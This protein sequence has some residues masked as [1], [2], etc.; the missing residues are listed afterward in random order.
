MKQKEG[1]FDYFP[2]AISGNPKKIIVSIII[3]TLIM[4]YFASQMEMETREESFEPETEKAEWLTE[5]Q[6][7]F[8]RIGEAV[9][10][11][12]MADEGN[13][14]N[15]TVMEDM[16]RTKEAILTSEKINRT[17]M[18]TDE[19]PDGMTT[20]A[21]TLIRANVT[22]ELEEILMKQSMEISGMTNS[23]ENQ[24][25][26]YSKR[27]SSLD[28]VSKLVYSQQAH[29]VENATTQ[30]ISMANINSNPQTWAVLG[31][32]GSEFYELTNVIREE[33]S[34]ASKIITLSEELI[35]KLEQDT[36][37]P[38]AD[39]EHFIG[40]LEGMK[41]NVMNTAGGDLYG[42][43][44]LSFLRFIEISEYLDHLEM[45]FTFQTKTP[46]IDMSLEEKKEKLENMT[47]EDIKK[48]VKDTINH[49]PEPLKESINETIKN[50]DDGRDNSEQSVNTLN[51]TNQ[52]LSDLIGYYS[53]NYSEENQV[54]V[55]DSL[56]EYQISVVENKTMIE[57]R[58]QPM[59]ESLRNWVRS[60][61]FL[62]NL[63][64]KLGGAITRTVSRDFQRV[65]IRAKSTISLVQMNSSI[66][67]DL[68]R[69]AQKEMITISDDNSFNSTN[70]VFAQQ[71]MMEEI[72]DSSNRSMNTLLPIAFIFVVIVLF[73]VYRTAIETIL[74][75]LSLSFAV[76]WTFGFGVILGYEFN[77]MIIAVP[78]LITGLVIDYG[79]HVIMRYREEKEKGKKN[80]ISTMIAISTVG[81]A[82]LLTSLTTA[83]GFLSN[84]FSNLTAMV[85]FGVLAAVGITS[86][87]ILMVA[88]L[89]SVIQLVENL[90]DK[91]GEENDTISSKGIVRKEK[92]LISSILSKS[93]DAS[94]RHPWI[95][96]FVVVLVT[97]SGFYGL[98]NI[99][100]TFEMRD[101]LPE[102]SSQSEN[103]KYIEDNFN[104][105]TSYVYIMSE[106]ELTDPNYLRA[107]DKT[108]QNAKDSEMVRVEE[109]V[110][111]PITVLRDYGMAVEGSMN[112]DPEIVENFTAS[113]IPETV[114]GWD[115]VEES[116]MSS[117][118]VS[119][120]YDLLYEKDVS[121][122]AISN[123][124]YRDDEGSYKKGVIR[125]RENNEKITD[126]LDNAKVLDEELHDDSKP[127]REAGYST[128]ITSGSIMG[129]ETTSELNNTQRNSLIATIIIVGIL[130]TLVF[131]YLHGSKVLG[132]LTTLPVALVTIWI[133]GTMYLMGVSLNVMTVSI[134]AL[135]VGMGIDYS[136][137][138]THRFTE[139]KAEEDNLYDAMHDTVQNTGAALFGSAATTVGAFGI[140]ATSDI[141]PL[142]QFGY[143]T[144]LAIAYSFLVAVFVL[145]SAL[146]LWA[147]CCKD[148]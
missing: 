36:F 109:G 19:I 5:I 130:L 53:E 137:H 141:L 73:I 115:D 1:L 79:I 2:S 89:P 42:N 55:L 49:D 99:D 7:D 145:P 105:S 97:L 35:Y 16:L 133:I 85:Q 60:A 132:A 20:L 47:D 11:A 26:M 29:V 100:T 122:R 43:N 34:N 54:R 41:N 135:T 118:D 25:A 138:I 66:E 84:T 6:E 64:E 147:K 56:G 78:I 106:G 68:R 71:V 75:L 143:I 50:L 104:I 24:S 8:G 123:V 94:D 74:S 86:S 98:I 112:Y 58:L 148:D 91:R 111:S 77:P 142:S 139:E 146:M 83:I 88:F 81:G 101:F 62:P 113:N 30:L 4:G 52:T 17:L 44:L 93:T 51:K 15:K 131:Y 82:L 61:S 107:V 38:G 65:D 28:N 70:K 127:L 108:I 63:V 3:F 80:S 102:D 21:D 10:I 40:L 67:R 72:E 134:T 12:F 37:T 92:S 57:Q 87:F 103:I 140:L 14:F 144:A 46:S 23:M 124:L 119:Q 13:V 22:L 117:D 114:E 59:L 27:Y 126:D 90:R 76:I 129:Q 121:R 45:D 18:F 125:L 48:T 116:D 32:Y 33:P 31:E 39:Q 136:I 69:E 120:L 128:M 95:V 96:L 9:Q 110:T